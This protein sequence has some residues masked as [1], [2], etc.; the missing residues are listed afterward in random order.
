MRGR[1]RKKD[2][3]FPCLGCG[4]ATAYGCQSMVDPLRTVLVRRPDESFAVPDPQSWGY[5]SR[6]NLDGAQREHDAFTSLLRSA[7][8]T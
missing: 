2:A 8:V 3:A 5:T 6:P 1:K 7:G 4:V